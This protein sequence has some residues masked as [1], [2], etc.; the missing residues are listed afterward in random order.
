MAVSKVILNGDTLI[1]VTQKTVTSASMLSGTTALKNDGTDITGSIASKTSSDLTANTLTVTAPAGY[2]ASAAT[3]TLSDQNL[4]A[5][6][7]KKDVSIFG[8]TG[9]YEGSG[10]GT[11]PAPP[12]QVNFIDYD[13]TIL[14]SYTKAEINAMTSESDLPAKPSHTGLTAQGWN[15]TLAQI[16]TQ[17][18]SAPDGYVWVGQMYI[19]SSGDTEIDVTFVDG[20]RLSPT[21][22][23]AVNGTV[24]VDWGDNTTADSVT[25]TSLSSRKA[26]P[27][28]YAN[29]GDYTITIH[30]VSGNFTFYG[31]STYTLLRKDTVANEN[32]VYSNCVQSVRL[33]SGITS[34]G[35]YAFSYC[36]SLAS[37]TIPSTVT[38]I[39]NF[40]FYYCYSLAS[41][42]IPSTVTSIGNYAFSY[43]TSLASLAIPSGVTG[44]VTGVFNYCYS[45][46]SLTIPSGVTGIGDNAF[47]YCYSLA[48][49]TIP[50]TVTSIGNSVFQSCYGIKEYHIKPTTV[51]TGGTSMFDGIV[52]DCVIYVPSAKLT[53]YQEASNWSTYASYM[54][55][56]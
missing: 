35:S 12:K 3:K 46:A 16:K 36:Y 24:T 8:V 44:F 31:T 37:L 49:L 17:L 48:S 33:G 9:T 53:D 13:G 47:Y 21:L 40:A 28:T 22:T 34:I 2:Y 26:V 41:L 10:G 5:G 19:T 7:I 20:A 42:T 6:N 29:V 39:G 11:S 45:L 23:I 32:R 27:H 15:W 14:Y 55:G 50:S 52:S 51:P 1:D 54:Q 56:E 25:G 18:T 43:C 38:S 4:S 30:V